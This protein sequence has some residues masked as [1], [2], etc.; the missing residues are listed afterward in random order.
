MINKVSE[1]LH[2]LVDNVNVNVTSMNETFTTRLNWLAED[3]K[4]NGVKT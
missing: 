4:T 2:H 1:K 3:E